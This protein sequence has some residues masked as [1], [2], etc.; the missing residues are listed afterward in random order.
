MCQ[1]GRGTS[2]ALGPGHD[3]GEP[4][5]CRRSTHANGCKVDAGA[6]NTLIHL[7]STEA[8]LFPFPIAAA[9]PGRVLRGSYEACG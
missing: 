9:D 6:S 4:E 3:P 8:S 2:V 5:Q 1:K 7:L